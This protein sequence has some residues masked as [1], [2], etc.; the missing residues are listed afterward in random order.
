MR[1]SRSTRNLDELERAIEGDVVVPG[2][3]AYDRLPR[4]FNA[5]FDGVVPHAAVPCR[6]AEDVAETISF[7]RRH[8]LESATRDGGHCFAGRS[9]TSGILI[10]VLP[11]SSVSVSDGVARV[12]AGARLGEVYLGMMAHDLTIPGGTCPSVGVAGLTLGGGLGILGRTYGVTSDRL[13]GA[14]I[15]LADGRILGCD[16]HHDEELFWAL[17]GA[18]IG[19]FGV[20]TDLVFRPIPTPTATN[21]HVT[22]PFSHAATVA[23]AWLRWGPTAPDELAASLV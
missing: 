9:S 8:R 21:F 3:P 10:D 12:G 22:W 1:E 7:A 17:R 20:V 6:S 18:G 15:V 14:R 2:S 16:E 23:Q 4:L 11:M 19:N 5:R 13:L